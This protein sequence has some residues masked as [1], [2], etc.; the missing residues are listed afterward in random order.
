MVLWRSIRYST[1]PGC[2][3]L[4][5][6]MLGVVKERVEEKSLEAFVGTSAKLYHGSF[7]APKMEST[8]VFRTHMRVVA[9][10]KTLHRYKAGTTHWYGR[11]VPEA[12]VLQLRSFH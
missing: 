4:L 2:H 7:A 3:H 12:R 1:K 11:S 8:A 6:Q 5:M 10:Q 9:M